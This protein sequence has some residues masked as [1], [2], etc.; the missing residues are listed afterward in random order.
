MQHRHHGRTL[1]ASF[2][3]ATLVLAACGSDD[4]GGGTTAAPTTVAST[5]PAATTAETTPAT[6][7]A[8]TEPAATEPAATEPAA[9]D[10]APSGTEGS[11]ETAISDER[12]A[13]NK[14]AGKI[15]YISSFDY[16]AAASILDVVVAKEK[17]YFDDL[18]LDVELQA[19]F[20]TSNYPLVAAN[21]AQFSS[22]G[23][24]TEILNYSVDGAKFVALADYGKTPIEALVTKDPTIT[25]L[26]QLKGKTIGVKGDIPPSIVAML[27]SAGL[28]RGVDYSEILV[29]GFDPVAHLQ[30]D[31]DALP[32]Y[33]SNEPGQLDAAG[34]KYGLFDPTDLGIPGT[35]GIL[36]T[37]ADFAAD[38]PGVVQDFI[39]AALKGMEDA[40]ADPAGAVAI[41]IK[42]ID[43]AGNAYYL[44]EAGETYRWQQESAEVLKGNPDGNVGSIDPAVFENEIAAY[45]EAGVFAEAPSTDGTYDADLAASLYDADGKVIWPG[46]G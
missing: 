39:R 37:S 20:S 1:L 13:A 34:V 26:A 4:D 44:T 11:G 6:E 15:T 3:M 23:S 28:T 18:C 38:N 12:C 2:A 9:T 27:S 10:T 45:T 31:I 46:E 42:Q 25:D 35:F 33:K 14:A 22:A 8:A 40:I 7:P 43:A 41:A 17:G 32:V 36:Y 16:A 21:T 29:D 30:L 5:E 19:G 24:Y